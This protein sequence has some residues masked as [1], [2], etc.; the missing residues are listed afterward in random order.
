[1]SYWNRAVV[2]FAVLALSF[3]AG[4]GSSS[5]P[6]AT[7]PPSGSFS[8][9]NLKGT[10]VFSVS[11][12]DVNNLPYAI[13]GTFTAN[14]SGGNGTGG[15]T[16]GTIDINDATFAESNPVIAP[17]SNAPIS[18]S[19]SYSVGVDGRGKAMLVTST[20]FQTI[21]LDFVLQDSSHGF[22]TESDGTAS[23]SGTLD[24]QTA[25]VTPSGTYAFSLAGA[26]ITNLDNIA[27]L[28]AVGNFTV[29]NDGAVT[30]LEDF[31]D[32]SFAY[33]DYTLSGTVV[34]GPSSTPA[35]TLTT[36]FHLETQ[37]YD[38]YAIDATHL[39]FIEMDNSAILSGDALSQTSATIPAGTWAF[40]TIGF[41]P[42][43]TVS[44]GGGFIVTDGNGNITSASSLDVNEGGTVS[45][46]PLSFTGQYAPAG[47]G[48]FLLSNLSNFLG[49][50]YAAYPYSGG[51]FLLEL[52]NS[53]GMDGAAYLQSS[54]TFD[55]SQ[56]YGLNLTGDN[57]NLLE[58]TG[59]P[60]E[61]DDIAEF[62]ASS[63]S[64]GSY[65]SSVLSGILDEN[66]DPEGAPTYD[67]TLCGSYNAP[68]SN[69]RGTMAAT[70]D[71]TLNGGFF[72]T[73]YTVD[74]TTFPFI[75]TDTTQV[76]IGAFVEQNAGAS[77]S[78]AVKPHAFLVR[79]LVRPHTAL[80]K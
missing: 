22:V 74:G 53:G 63:T 21:V 26:D 28:D 59:V 75:E 79:S 80:K 33:P 48:R 41:F 58:T 42:S 54:T 55:A 8:N 57:F 66:Y 43:T 10:Y 70:T 4:C 5:G 51:F 29:G 25:G 23:G 38:V 69:G 46:S 18:G 73:F 72:L 15:I 20:P 77:S 17:I 56:G 71:N 76:A 40:T 12:T 47:T 50:T 19:S 68:D 3:L 61:V 13:V 49:A 16:G 24:L 2:P 36:G 30:G 1:M 60:E 62:A 44:T 31:N 6:V 52:D 32:S 35:T 9:S 11:G 14:G 34:L 37:T 64:C 45:P 27:S 39:K 78:A 67:V 65:T 7:P